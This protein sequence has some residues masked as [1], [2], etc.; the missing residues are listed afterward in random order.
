MWSILK[1]LWR[2]RRMKNMYAVEYQ[3]S[4]MLE[5]K[6]FAYEYFDEDY[7]T[8]EITFTHESAG[9]TL[10]LNKKKLEWYQTSKLGINNDFL[11]N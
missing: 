1:L 5:P 9:H 3:T 6:L 2:A 11:N 8:H 10:V 7:H 4:S